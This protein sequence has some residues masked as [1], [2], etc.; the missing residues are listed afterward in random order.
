MKALVWYIDL[1]GIKNQNILRY[2]YSTLT[3][4][5]REAFSIVDKS[6]DGRA[7]P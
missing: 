6:D 5:Q 1:N 3:G 2:P 7:H 4:G